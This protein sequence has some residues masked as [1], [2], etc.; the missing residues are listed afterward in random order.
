MTRTIQ[1]L[2]LLIGSTI[3]VA[4]FGVAS[5][6]DAKTSATDT[7]KGVATKSASAKEARPETPEKLLE[8]KGLTKEEHKYLL[9]ED[10]ALKKYE[11]AKTD[12]SAFQKA[13]GKAATIVQYDDMLAGMQMEQ[14]E[15][16]QNVSMM[17]MQINNS[18][19][20][21][22]GMMR[23]VQNMQLA[24]MRAQ[25]S[26]AQQMISQMN[27]Q[28]NAYKNQGPKQDERNSAKAEF[29]RT[30]LAFVNK[31]DELNELV[32]PLLEKYH[33]LTRDKSVLNALVEIRKSTSKTYKLGPSDELAAAAKM[34]RDVKKNTT[35]P[36]SSPK[37]T[38]KK[39]KK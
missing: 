9:D 1:S 4:G 37:R 20:G 15:M 11:E 29:D 30:R 5:A 34:V 18:S 38:K 27:T 10:Q 26:Q 39:G 24:P 6:D 25:V 14:Q 2:A 12:Y 33:E 23:R 36:A 17:Q 31:V 13:F 16:Q 35:A 22:F 8:S 21:G 28:I 32:A 3:L 19:R 7:E